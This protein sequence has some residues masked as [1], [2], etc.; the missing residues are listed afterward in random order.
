V[1]NFDQLKM[2]GE[3]FHAILKDILPGNE[4]QAEVAIHALRFKKLVR[5]VYNP[6]M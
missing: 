5:L 3:E 6:S 2:D 4:Q 1:E